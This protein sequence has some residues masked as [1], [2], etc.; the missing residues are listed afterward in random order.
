MNANRPI[1]FVRCQ[2]KGT[3][4]GSVNLIGSRI[5]TSHKEREGHKCEE[6]RIARVPPHTQQDP[7][8]GGDTA[9]DRQPTPFTSAK[10]Y[11]NK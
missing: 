8:F 7:T 3:C 5:S 4:R 10:Y 1:N 9:G 2:S 11:I 6:S